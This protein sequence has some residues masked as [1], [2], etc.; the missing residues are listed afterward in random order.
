MIAKASVKVEDTSHARIS[1]HN[2]LLARC[3]TIIQRLHPGLQSIEHIENDTLH[4]EL[5]QG[6]GTCLNR[7]ELLRLGR[8]LA[9]QLGLEIQI[10][11]HREPLQIHASNHDGLQEQ[12][13]SQLHHGLDTP[14][15]VAPTVYV[16]PYHEP[17]SNIYDTIPPDIISRIH[18]I[19][20]LSAIEDQSNPS[21]GP[22]IIGIKAALNK[23]SVSMH[24][25]KLHTFGGFL[26]VLIDADPDIIEEEA[27]YELS[28]EL[29]KAANGQSL[30]VTVAPRRQHIAEAPREEEKHNQDDFSQESSPAQENTVTE[31][32]ELK[33]PHEITAFCE[34][35]LTEIGTSLPYTVTFNS[36]TDQYLINLLYKRSA[37]SY[38]QS[39]SDRISSLITESKLPI[40]VTYSHV[41]RNTL[42]LNEG[43]RPTISKSEML[44]MAAL[45]RTNLHISDESEW[46]HV[47]PLESSH[48]LFSN[49]IEISPKIRVTASLLESIKAAA[50][51]IPAPILLHQPHTTREYVTPSEVKAITKM[52]LPPTASLGTVRASQS[53]VIRVNIQASRSNWPSIHGALSAVFQSLDPDLQE[54]IFHHEKRHEK[55][56][57]AIAR[58]SDLYRKHFIRNMDQNGEISIREWK[59]PPAKPVRLTEC[60]FQSLR[61]RYP[62]IVDRTDVP[63][64]L[65]DVEGTARA[66]DGQSFVIKDGILT[67]GIHFANAAIQMEQFSHERHHAYMRGDSVYV[68]DD[69]DLMIAHMLPG[70]VRHTFQK[71][72]VSPALS[73]FIEYPLDSWGDPAAIAK[74]IDNARIEATFVRPSSRNFYPRGVAPDW[75]KGLPKSARRELAMMSKIGAALTRYS[76]GFDLPALEDRIDDPRKSMASINC[77]ANH[78]LAKHLATSNL[79]CLYHATVAPTPE[80][81]QSSMNALKFFAAEYPSIAALYQHSPQEVTADGHLLHQLFVATRLLPRITAQSSSF[82]HITEAISATPGP[83][84]LA[85]Y[86]PYIGVNTGFRKLVSLVAQHQLNASLGLVTPLSR[87]EVQSIYNRQINQALDGHEERIAE[88]LRMIGNLNHLE[89]ASSAP[90]WVRARYK[91]RFDTVEVEVDLPFNCSC[92]CI[93]LL[94]PEEATEVR[95]GDLLRVEPV[96]YS[97]INNTLFFQRTRQ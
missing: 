57:N 55:I 38:F 87:G 14:I 18:V 26:H 96:H 97:L 19:S 6:N 15:I 17:F 86:N 80:A 7:D 22:A 12:Q 72:A 40:A 42:I 30:V 67:H 94:L 4:I 76:S 31:S 36:Y 52:I 95:A 56:C 91:P 63:V 64:S 61:K 93:A 11:N 90:V 92:R 53:G 29:L 21:R 9:L 49:C 32:I 47:M 65:W 35:L 20:L 2:G 78:I 51:H 10:S 27:F 62:S 89:R 1:R 3:N 23:F 25:A 71:G 69:A 88:D 59:P 68:H 82:P 13:K 70:I 16:V 58:R 60:S 33:H 48:N 66:E 81:I 37:A 46:A 44:K 54:V 8:T 74:S 79:P 34:R 24:E 28:Q 39:I 50:T 75:Q 83:H 85:G 77:I 73:V 41:Q 5:S 84:V 43:R 45:I